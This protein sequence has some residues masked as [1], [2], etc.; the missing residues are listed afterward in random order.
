MAVKDIM[1][2]N[3]NIY[4]RQKVNEKVL[5]QTY[6]FQ[7]KYGFKMGTGKEATHNNEADAFK[8]AFMQAYLLIMHSFYPANAVKS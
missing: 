8:H 5:S 7:K 6:K 1:E 3:F 4:N 2:D